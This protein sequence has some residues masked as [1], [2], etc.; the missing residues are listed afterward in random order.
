MQNMKKKTQ[1]SRIMVYFLFN[2]TF[3]EKIC[4]MFETKYRDLSF[5]I[6]AISKGVFYLFLL[7]YLS[8]HTNLKCYIKA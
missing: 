1:H 2:S 7:F 5:F 3:F 8:F 6:D 4:R